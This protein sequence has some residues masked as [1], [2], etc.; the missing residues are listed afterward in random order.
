MTRQ[1]EGATGSG[2]QNDLTLHF[3]LGDYSGS[4][5]LEVTWPG[6]TTQALS[7]MPN[8]TKVISLFV[9][10]ADRSFVRATNC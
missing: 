8:Q 6:G 7:A 4:V 5:S 3:G 9:P 1:V 10:P 2:N